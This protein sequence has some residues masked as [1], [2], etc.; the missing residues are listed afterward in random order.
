MARLLESD[1]T[2][3]VMR[4][5][6]VLLS[7]AVCLPRAG[8][9]DMPSPDDMRLSLAAR[10]A[11]MDDFRFFY[12]NLGVPVKDGVATVWWPVPSAD[13]PKQIVD[14]VSKV[15]G[16]KSVRNEMTVLPEDEWPEQW[17]HV[18]PLLRP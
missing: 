1:M 10:N 7:L 8:A 6:C 11:L 5:L 3:Y 13:A 17:H 9:A 18:Q 14:R 16:I 15:K 2:M 4:R 12:L